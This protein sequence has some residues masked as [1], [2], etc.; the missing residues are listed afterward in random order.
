MNTNGHGYRG[1]DPMQ[2]FFQRR[3]NDG[4]PANSQGPGQGNDILRRHVND[5]GQSG[6]DNNGHNAASDV[7]PQ[8]NQGQN[9]A[10]ESHLRKFIGLA[11]NAALA[12]S[13]PLDLWLYNWA[14][15]KDG[16]INKGKAFVAAALIDANQRNQQN[17]Q[18]APETNRVMDYAKKLMGEWTKPKPEK[19][20][21][22]EQD[23]DPDDSGVDL[24]YDDESDG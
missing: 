5:L 13:M 22:K 2:G 3:Q 19:K 17:M 1:D 10:G 6:A 18:Q 12:A 8:D 23:N 14:H 15:N 24:G 7:G 20:V 9:R 4:N 21:I 16:S 11:A